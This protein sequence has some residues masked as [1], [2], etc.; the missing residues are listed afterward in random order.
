MWN[1]RCQAAGPVGE[2]VLHGPWPGDH[3]K[4]DAETHRIERPETPAPARSSTCP[5]P[6]PVGFSSVGFLKGQTST[7]ELRCALQ[8]GE[9]AVRSPA[10][11]SAR[12]SQDTYVW[13]KDTHGNVSRSPTVQN[14]EQD[15]ALR[16]NLS[17][18]NAQKCQEAQ[19][20]VVFRRGRMP[21]G[22]NR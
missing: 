9:K 4:G 18:A 21:L 8:E 7:R 1:T 16:P 6:Y 15:K 13:T 22:A 14:V 3:E 5:E 19:V 2:Q 10:L 17:S 11:A 12:S 20:R